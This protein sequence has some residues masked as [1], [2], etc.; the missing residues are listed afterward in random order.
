MAMILL[1]YFILSV[2]NRGIG[3][4]FFFSTAT[5]KG[6]AFSS[7]GIEAELAVAVFFFIN[8]A[9]RNYNI[10]DRNYLLHQTQ[11][12]NKYFFRKT[13]KGAY[14]AV[15]TAKYALEKAFL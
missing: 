4:Q 3:L 10:A 14:F 8:I 13:K 11:I 1:N 6:S 5:S 12:I 15:K 9:D 7:F 2:S